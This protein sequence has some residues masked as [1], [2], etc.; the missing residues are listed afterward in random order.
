MEKILWQ[1]P[2]DRKLLVNILYLAGV[3]NNIKILPAINNWVDKKYLLYLAPPIYPV[4]VDIA[5]KERKDFFTLILNVVA[6]LSPAKG[7]VKTL[8]KLIGIEDLFSSS[9]IGGCSLWVL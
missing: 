4:S 3:I 5:K 6:G 2:L 9:F 1:Y 7:V 8:R